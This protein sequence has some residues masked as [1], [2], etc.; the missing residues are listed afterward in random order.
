VQGLAPAL[1]FPA[2]YKHNKR[3]N[4][5]VAEALTND[6]WIRDV[7]HDL[8]VPL[9]D[10]LVQ[11]WGMI[12]DVPFDLNNLELD[13]ILWIRT[14][15]GDYSAKSAYELQFK[16]G[17]TSC[18]SRGFYLQ[19][20][21]F[22]VEGLGPFKMQD[23]SSLCGCFFGTEFG[24]LTGCLLENGQIPISALYVGETYRQPNIFF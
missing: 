21:T 19:V 4:R 2:L 15:S 11:L 10:A 13:M 20:S 7:S 3:K 9:I 12:E 24:Q 6:Q 14:A 8:T 1:L 22:G 16:G 17:Y 23:A 18:N 5:T